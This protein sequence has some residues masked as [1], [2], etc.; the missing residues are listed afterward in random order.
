MKRL[1]LLSAVVIS[2]VAPTPGFA[3]DN[4]APPTY[5]ASLF[6]GSVSSYLQTRTGVV[7]IAVYDHLTHK[8]WALL[9]A[10]LNH[11]AS[12]SKVD[13]MAAYL[14]QLQVKK[15]S[16]TAANLTRLTQMIEYSDNADA[17]YFYRLIGVCQGLT[18][19]NAM[20]PLTATT[21]VC[22]HGDIY[23]WGIMNTTVLDQLRVVKL[24]STKNS[25]LTAASRK[26]GL[27]LMEHISAGDTWGVSTGPQKGSTV[28]FKNGWSPLTSTSDWQI[29]SIGWIRGSGRNY[30]IA[31]M[32]SGD[33]SFAY[34]VATI[35]QTAQLIWDI[36]TK[37][38]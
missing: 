33:P 7:S 21:P 35:G 26:L 5:S 24:F 17:A 20:I 31:V 13:I 4:H 15:Q 1:L 23:G 2:I 34:G 37:N 3:K 14:H 28:A 22:P 18:T 10:K 9:P 27:S 25:I 16:L 36:L 12:V 29:N 11:A 8:T 32:S 38:K 19:F 30:D 6:A